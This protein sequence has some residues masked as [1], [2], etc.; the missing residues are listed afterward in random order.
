MA[1]CV[2]SGDSTAGLTHCK[3]GRW[4][5]A[6]ASEKA[7]SS[8]RSNA[9]LQGMWMLSSEGADGPLQQRSASMVGR[10][11]KPLQAFF[12]MKAY[13]INNSHF[14]RHAICYTAKQFCLSTLGTSPDLSIPAPLP[15]NYGEIP[16]KQAYTGKLF[17]TCTSYIRN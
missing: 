12:T 14:S 2:E 10:R 11:I 15:D 5:P 4:D 1:D 17:F 8:P 6:E 3:P 7:S 16:W 13:S 9:I